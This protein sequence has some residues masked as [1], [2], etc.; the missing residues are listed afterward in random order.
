MDWE[1]FWTDISH[2][3][4]YFVGVKRGIQFGLT[5]PFNFSVRRP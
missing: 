4:S 1:F 5:S 2:G 3:F